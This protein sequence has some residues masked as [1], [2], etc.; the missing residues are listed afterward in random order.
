MCLLIYGACVIAGCDV[1]MSCKD[2]YRAEE[3][4]ALSVELVKATNI[5]NASSTCALNSQFLAY[6]LTFHFSLQFVNQ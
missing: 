1:I 2:A 3:M 4:V 5:S 6:W